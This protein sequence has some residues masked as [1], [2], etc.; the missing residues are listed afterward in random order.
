MFCFGFARF[1][2]TIASY[3]NTHWLEAEEKFS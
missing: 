2:N 3:Y 1:I